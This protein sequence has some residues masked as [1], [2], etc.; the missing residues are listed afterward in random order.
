MKQGFKYEVVTI[1]QEIEAST[2]LLITKKV[3]FFTTEKVNFLNVSISSC[4]WR[5]KLLKK[6]AL[7]KQGFKYEVLTIFQEIEASTLLLITKKVRFFITKKVNFLN[8]SI[9]SCW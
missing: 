3:R 1:F 9:S 4:W 5:D 8:I 2:L 6:V 7:L